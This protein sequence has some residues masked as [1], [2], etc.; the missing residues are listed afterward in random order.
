MIK[1]NSYQ[2]TSF[3]SK[4]QL[5]EFPREILKRILIEIIQN[6]IEKIPPI[7]DKLILLLK[8]KLSEVIYQLI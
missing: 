4:I 5:I 2:N 1:I 6:H 3:E 8:I 7:N